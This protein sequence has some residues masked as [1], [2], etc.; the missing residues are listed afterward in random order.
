[1]PGR[2]ETRWVEVEGDHGDSPTYE[3][4]T[5]AGATDE[6][7]TAEEIEGY[8][9]ANEEAAAD[10]EYNATAG[11]IEAAAQLGVDLSTVT[12]T[13]YEGRI[14]KADVEAAAE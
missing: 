3:R 14:T 10:S 1:M 7:R 8:E 5:P 13:G 11:A 6:E 2:D 4:I 12:G 9:T